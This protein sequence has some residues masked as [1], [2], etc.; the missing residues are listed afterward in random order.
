MHFIDTIQTILVACTLMSTLVRVSLRS[1]GH[2]DE[3][4]ACP[5]RSLEASLSTDIVSG[6]ISIN[7]CH[8]V[9]EETPVQELSTLQLE[10]VCAVE[11]PKFPELQFYRGYA[12]D[13]K[14]QM[15]IVTQ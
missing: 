1:E 5:L 12:L 13:S 6:S 2:R 8:D 7:T 15:L 9:E 3:L 10:W 14:K 4:L 11:E